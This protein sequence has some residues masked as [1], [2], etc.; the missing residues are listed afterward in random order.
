M[1]LVHVRFQFFFVKQPDRIDCVKGVVYTIDTF[2]PHTYPQS[3]GFM[4]T[5]INDGAYRPV[6]ATLRH[7][8]IRTLQD[9]THYLLLYYRT[10][11]C[12][13]DIRTFGTM[14]ICTVHHAYR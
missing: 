8:I 3:T 2:G 12:R 13:A 1:Y 7:C 11:S 5:P 9:M 14:Y 6:H 10:F 4:R